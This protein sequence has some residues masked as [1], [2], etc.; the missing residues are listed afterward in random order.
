V[1]PPSSLREAGPPPGLTVDNGLAVKTET[2]YP[3]TAEERTR[4]ILSRRG[5]RRALD[6]REPVGALVESEPS[7]A[8][9]TVSVATVFLANREC[10]WHC[11]MCDL[12][13]ATLAETVPEGAIAEQVRK[14]LAGLPPARWVKLYN[15]GSFFD[16]RAIPRGEYEPVA[17]EIA[18]FERVIVESHPALVGEDVL[19]LRDLVRGRL[20]VA[21]GLET[22]HPGVL[23][24]LNKGMTLDDF[25]RAAEKLAQAGVALRAFVLAGLPFLRDEEAQDWTARSIGFAFDCG[26]EVVAVIPTRPGNGALDALAARGEFDPPL[27]AALEAA[28]AAGLESQRGRVL[29]DLWD[30]ERFSSCSDCFPVRRE[31]LNAMNLAQSVLPKVACARCGGQA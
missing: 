17:R 4:W 21:M 12:W 16:P 7:E 24:R 27:L 10:P 9:E 15:A 19:R 25:G 2:P 18:G 31:R 6:P 30:L 23:A 22:I 14:A 5:L 3:A 13:Q 29:A 1:P 26:A 8:G 20:E 28:A 11:L